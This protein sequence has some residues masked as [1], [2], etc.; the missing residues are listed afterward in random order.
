MADSSQALLRSLGKHASK[1]RL[2]YQ[3]AHQQ[4]RLG[5]PHAS[6][7]ALVA[8][9]EPESTCTSK[10]YSTMWLSNYR[11]QKQCSNM[12]VRASTSCKKLTSDC[13][14]GFPWV[15]VAAV[16]DRERAAKGS[17]YTP[18]PPG[19]CRG[20]APGAIWR[21]PRASAGEPVRRLKS[22]PAGS[23]K[24][25]SAITLW[26]SCPPARHCCHVTWFGKTSAE[27]DAL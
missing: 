26:V 27:G 3:R 5:R 17:N 23:V 2:N 9:M 18:T 13:S 22:P 14:L 25:G 10:S 15:K 16:R 1:P 19:G 21:K 20:P 8:W 11:Q 24:S 12:H 4:H 6:S 7:T